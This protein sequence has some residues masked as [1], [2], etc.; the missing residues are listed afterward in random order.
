M[1]ENDSDLSGGHQKGDFSDNSIEMVQE[2]LKENTNCRFF[3][4]W[5]PETASFLTTEKFALVHV[6]M[7]YYQSTVSCIDVFWNRI[8][9]GGVMIFD[10]YE[11]V[12][13]PGVKRAL[14]EFFK[15]RTDFI[16]ENSGIHSIA[17]FKKESEQPPLPTG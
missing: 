16:P 14:S 9:L 2:Y 17:Y 6:D 13:C 5:F 3:K 10:D 1:M 15:D 4:G 12:A 11:W 8:Q 7:D